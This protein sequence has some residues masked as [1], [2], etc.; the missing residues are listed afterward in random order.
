MTL[1]LEA[2]TTVVAVGGAGNT[3]GRF[4]KARICQRIHWIRNGIAHCGSRRV[5][6]WQ[7]SNETDPF[8]V[9]VVLTR[10][11]HRR[12]TRKYAEGELPPDRCFYFRGADAKLNIR[13]HNLTMF[14]QIAEGV[15]DATWLYHLRQGDYSRW[16]RTGIHDN[17]LADEAKKIEALQDPSTK[18]T[19]EKIKQLIER[20][21]TLPEKAPA[22]TS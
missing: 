20:Y 7:R 5:V 3:I 8:R 10:A 6:L 14:N 18:D 22:S 16:F 2:V 21:Y 1:A 4:C 15:D 13:V 11:E 19:R 9:N 12:H 17:E